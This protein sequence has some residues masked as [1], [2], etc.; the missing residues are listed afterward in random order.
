MTEVPLLGQHQRILDSNDIADL[1]RERLHP[2]VTYSVLWREAGNLA[3]LMWLRPGSRVPEHV[4][5]HAHHHVWLVDGRARVDGR[6]LS[7]GAYWHVP[8]GAPHSV[9]G[10]APYG[11]QLF[12]LYLRER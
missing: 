10:L 8:A 12:Y 7:W 5:E 6:L 1:P 3:G 11:S 9:E 2:G 4:H